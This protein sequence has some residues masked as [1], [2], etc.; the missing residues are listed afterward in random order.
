MM[1]KDFAAIIAEG[2]E[3]MM[4][5][6]KAYGEHSAWKKV[7]AEVAQK[8]AQ[9]RVKGGYCPYLFKAC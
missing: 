8:K 5:K 9:V 7:S 1:A 4:A 3:V 2:K 6:Y